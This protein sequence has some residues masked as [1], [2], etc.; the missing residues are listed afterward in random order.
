[1][2]DQLRRHL[3][4]ANVMATLALF[5]ALGGSSYAAIELGR[6]SVKSRNIAP[7]AVTTL[8]DGLLASTD[9]HDGLWQGWLERDLDAVPARRVPGVEPVRRR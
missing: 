8:T 2:L 3:S 6:N 5:V 1:M 9:H 7:G 4:Y